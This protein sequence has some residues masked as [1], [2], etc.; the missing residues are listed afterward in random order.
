MSACTN[1]DLSTCDNGGACGICFMA[2]SD[3]ECDR[4]QNELYA[5]PDAPKDQEGR[6]I[7]PDCT[8]AIAEGD[9]CEAGGGRHGS[10]TEGGCGT[11]NINN[12]FGG[13]DVYLRV[14]CDAPP[15]PPSPPAPPPFPPSPPAPPLPP[16]PPPV[17]PRAGHNPYHSPVTWF[18]H[19]HGI[20]FLPT[21]AGVTL[22]CCFCICRCIYVCVRRRARVS[23]QRKAARSRKEKEIALTSVLS[24]MPT[25]PY[26]A[27]T[28]SSTTDGEE[29]AVCLAKFEDGT[30]VRRLNCG[31]VFHLD[32][33]EKW[34]LGS[35]AA[36][37]PRCPVCRAV[38]LS[39]DEL[40][41]AGIE[42]DVDC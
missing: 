27:T 38:P 26:A 13:H 22:I 12:C 35:A 37:L 10:A 30:T 6:P 17:M 42:G 16:P 21:F 7:V 33:V 15:F 36:D 34:L 11:E 29:C 1:N 25:Q 9:F 23:A 31:H 5:N 18:L 8:P 19:F 4:I 39:A 28:T 2:A 20:W 32:C 3:A 40:R 41:R 14:H 24:A